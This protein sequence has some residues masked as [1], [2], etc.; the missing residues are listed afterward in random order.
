M[1]F[2]SL[3]VGDPLNDELTIIIPGVGGRSESFKFLIIFLERTGVQP[4]SSLSV[5]IWDIKISNIKK[6]GNLFNF[7]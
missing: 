7:F 4:H 2:C 1:G 5:L 3:N 6:M